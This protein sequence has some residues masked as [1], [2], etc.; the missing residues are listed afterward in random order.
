MDRAS[1]KKPARSKAPV[2]HHS[3]KV[4][5]AGLS[6]EELTTQ[7]AELGL[8][9]YRGK[10]IWGWMYQKGVK[11][12]DQMTNLS[13]KDQRA[14]SDKFVFDWG[15]AQE[16]DLSA[17]G[18]RKL[19]VSFGK[20][21]RSKCETVF[22]PFE[23]S[24]DRYSRG[25]LCISS[26]FG[27]SLACT[28]CRTGTQPLFRNLTAAEIVGQVM[29][30]R[31]TLGEF[32]MQADQKRSV[33]NI[34]LMGEGE[35]LYNYRQIKKAL[36]ILTD[37]DGC[38]I[39]KR[40]ITLSTSG[41]VPLIEK[42]RTELGVNLAVS[43]HA[44]THDVRSEIM[45]INKTYPLDALM[46]A[47]GKY[48]G[49]IPPSAAERAAEAEARGGNAE[50]SGSGLG[51]RRRVTFE[52]VMLEGVNDSVL[53]ARELTALL[54]PLHQPLVNLIPFNPWEGSP[55][56]SSSEQA[57]IAFAAELERLG[58]PVTVRWPRGRDISAACGQLKALAAAQEVEVAYA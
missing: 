12:F 29:L 13:N 32:P 11:G 2:L 38:G 21:Q 54:A 10:Q 34:V 35:P 15:R 51:R 55:Y 9:P 23:G 6:R 47:C 41:V 49:S 7:V 36:A 33:S 14:L 39:G 4:N 31:H 20:E 30:M 5:L 53:Q 45:A 19:L 3:G 24:I 26:Q 16:D 44:P 18:T 27:C 8:A 57:V 52:Y 17:D 37:G 56:L 22:I 25:T 42:V 1:D 48:D 28:F 50:A 43:L 40:R 46:E 58:Q